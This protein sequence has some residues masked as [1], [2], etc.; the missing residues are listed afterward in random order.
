M[1]QPATP[2]AALGNWSARPTHRAWLAARADDLFTLFE[3][4]PNPAG[5]FS[6]LDPSGEPVAGNAA[7]P[8]HATARMAHCFAIG[9]LL[10]R[11]GAPEIVDHAMTFL[12]TR[13][14]D[15]ARGGYFWSVD[16][17]AAVDP[18][19][20][21]YGHAFVLLA[22]ASALTVGHPL[23]APMLADVSEILGTRF[24]EPAHGA[25]A[26]EFAPDWTP[27]PG[28]RGQN[29]NMHL[30]EALM[31]AFEATAE[32]VYL[33][34]AEGIADLIIRRAAAAAGWRVPEH[35]TEAWQVDPHYRGNEMFR[36]AGTTPGHALEWSRLLLQLWCLGGRRLDWLP[37]AAAA[38]FERAMTLGW[39]AEHGGLFYTLD[40]ENRPLR[41]IKLWWPHCEGIGA[42]HFLNAHVPDPAHEAAYRRLWG[43]VSRAFLDRRHGGWHEELAEDLT[44]AFTLFPG[45]ADIYHALQACLIPLYPATASL[46]RVIAQAGRAG[47]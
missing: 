31:A 28:Y 27:V 16:D 21:A 45:K 12:W 24:W 26:E 20:Q 14:R 34:R 10:G 2:D 5:G 37:A 17:A 30:T 44:P 3:R 36:P 15:A 23:A 43:L 35:F 7:R 13:H 25:A 4:A 32:R 6:D 33:D 11:P 47:A 46:T 42:A 40:W 41:R 9:T 38:L 29:A 39:D 1:I 18:A 8:I 19:K 22:A